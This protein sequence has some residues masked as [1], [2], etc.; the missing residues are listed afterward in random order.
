MSG[1]VSLTHWR[2][3]GGTYRWLVN[4][5]GVRHVRVGGVGLGA[6]GGVGLGLRLGLIICARHIFGLGVD[7][8][9]CLAGGRILVTTRESS[10]SNE[11]G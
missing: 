2:T 3:G 11:G 9:L 6:D 4:S 7:H 5:G 8:G 10:A 1:T